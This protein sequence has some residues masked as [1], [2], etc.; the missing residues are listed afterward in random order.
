VISVGKNYFTEEQIIEL[1][2]N[3]YV[4]KVS[5]K[6]ITYTDEFKSVFSKKY[7]EG[8]PPSTILREMGFDPHVLGKK[9]IDRFVG[10]VFKYEARG[11]DYSD[12]RQESSGR[13]STK[14][15]TAEEQ[16]AR[17]KHQVKYLKQENEFLKKVHFWDRQAQQKHL[18]SRKKSSKS[19]G[20]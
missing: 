3:P 17:L 4:K 1:E 7:T 20:R 8:N 10:N 15:L 12:L 14:D 11:G 2:R 19:C 16:I 13:P 9:R 6:A 18:Q 5:K